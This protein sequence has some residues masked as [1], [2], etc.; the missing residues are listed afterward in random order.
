VVYN[1][2]VDEMYYAEK[3][4]GSYLNGKRIFVSQAKSMKESLISVGTSPYHKHEADEVFRTFAKIYKDC[5]DLRRCG[6]A[7][8]DMAHVACGRIEGYIEKKLK[9]WD[10]AAGTVIVREAGG[11]VL[12]YEGMDRTM[13]LM[14]DVVVGNA[15][16]API[17]AKEY[18]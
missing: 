8:L 9:L 12:D 15:F 13:E 16:I 18:L 1:P 7:A 3:G 6:S 10:F 17:L 11:K 4:K 2:F 5:Q 14:G